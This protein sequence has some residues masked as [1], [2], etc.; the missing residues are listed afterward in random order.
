MAYLGRIPA[1]GSFEKL[2]SI[3]GLQ[4]G[5]RTTF[6]LTVSGQQYTPD[7]VSQLMVVKNGVTL[8][9][10]EGFSV[11]G[12]SITIT[13]VLQSN[14]NVWILTYGQAKFT[15][16]PSAGTVTSDKIAPSSIEYDKLSGDTVATIIGNIITFGI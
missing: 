5:V 11:G 2:D 6:P 10:G 7:G 4:D 12:S 15:G 16:V 3:R 8:E 13:P 9:P 14:D 1:V